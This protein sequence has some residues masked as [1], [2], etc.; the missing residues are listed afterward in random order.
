MKWVKFKSDFI[1]ANPPL[2]RLL[3]R[4]DTLID[5]NKRGIYA[6]DEIEFKEKYTGHRDPKI[7]NNEYFH[8][9]HT[10][11]PVPDEYFGSAY[12]EKRTAYETYVG[13]WVQFFDEQ[14]R[15]GDTD[16]AVYFDWDRGRGSVIIYILQLLPPISWINANIHIANPPNSDPPPPPH[17]PPW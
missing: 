8:Y 13:G 12:F 7:G 16:H 6:Y 11:A 1:S 15:G 3:K 10:R 2:G 14:V 17:Q 9:W 4:G 5:F